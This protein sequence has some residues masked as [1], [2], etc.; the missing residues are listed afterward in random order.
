MAYIIRNVTFD[1][2]YC[3][4]DEYCLSKEGSFC[5]PGSFWVSKNGRYE[6]GWYRF[7][8]MS[9]AYLETQ[10]LEGWEDRSFPEGL[11]SRQSDLSNQPSLS[12][13][14]HG[15]IVLRKFDENRVKEIL[16]DIVDASAATD[17]IEVAYDL[18]SVF[19]EWWMLAPGLDIDDSG[20]EPA[21]ILDC[22]DIK[23]DSG[24]WNLYCGHRS[25][26]FGRNLN[27]F[28]DSLYEG[29][30]WQGRFRIKIIN[31]SRLKIFQGGKF[32]GH[33]RE[34]VDDYNKGT[35]DNNNYYGI[36]LE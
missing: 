27:A 9:P 21:L 35:K 36:D 18:E 19:V 10:D 14:Y 4:T 26:G 6:V 20:D 5:I 1:M 15:I 24:F 34:I 29:P 16:Q 3:K 8:V 32:Y 31:T 12:F 22:S 11:Y 2:E 17:D 23:T 28:V 30:G 7:A 13:A 33:L 25:D